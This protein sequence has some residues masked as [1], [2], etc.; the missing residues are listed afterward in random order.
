[1]QYFKGSSYKG[2]GANFLLSFQLRI[3]F[4]APSKMVTL[5]SEAFTHRDMYTHRKVNTTG[6]LSMTTLDLESTKKIRR[7]SQTH[8]ATVGMCLLAGAL[9]RYFLENN[10]KDQLPPWISIMHS[11]P[12]PGHPLQEM[13]NH[14][15][16]S[17]LK[18]SF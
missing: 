16:V 2:I 13:V 17:Y 10:L 6:V 5:Y 3:V 4:T 9:R 8:F 14:W 7:V 11:L 1:M 15:Q 18:Y 12:R